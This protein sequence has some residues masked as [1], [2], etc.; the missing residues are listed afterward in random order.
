MNSGITMR[1][2]TATLSIIGGD[3][4]LDGISRMRERPIKSLV[5]SLKNIG[6][7]INYKKNNGFPPLKIKNKSHE[8]DQSTVEIDG[9]ASSQFISALIIGLA[10]LKRRIKIKIKGQKDFISICSN[11]T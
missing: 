2:L 8:F 9:S 3:Y 11:D 7:Q 5:D 4:I 6:C 1:F 10:T